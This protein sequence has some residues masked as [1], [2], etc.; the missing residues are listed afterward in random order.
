MCLFGSDVLVIFG[1]V[2][3][4][5]YVFVYYDDLQV[6][7]EEMLVNFEV[8]FFSVGMFVGFDMYLLFKVYVCYLVDVCVVCDF[9]CQCLLGV[10]VLLLYGDICCSEL[11]VEIDGWCYV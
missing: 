1:I 2:V 3:V 9:F 4:I 6:Q 5:G 11:L 7:L 10:L 8:L